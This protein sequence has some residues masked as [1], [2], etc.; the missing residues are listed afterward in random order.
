[1]LLLHASMPR[2]SRFYRP[3][4]SGCNSAVYQRGQRPSPSRNKE[5]A[6]KQ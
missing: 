4:E 3:T 6:I 2:F 5:V 1:M